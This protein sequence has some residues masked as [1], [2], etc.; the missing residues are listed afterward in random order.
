MPQPA[1]HVRPTRR[2]APTPEAAVPEA[3]V[4]VTALEGGVDDP[5]DPRF[6]A[7]LEAVR[8]VPAARGAT[9]SKGSL[10]QLRG[11]RRDDLFAVAEVAYAYLFGGHERVALVLFEGLAAVAP[12]EPY[13][14]LA[15]GLSHDFLGDLDAAVRAYDRAAKLDPEDPRPDINRAEIHLE[16]RELKAAH[17]LLARAA[18]KAQRDDVLTAKIQALDGQVRRLARRRG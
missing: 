15:C 18:G 8:V 2:R 4:V 12:D 17:S 7:E 9:P 10:E 3:Y 6:L 14:A 13:F 1:R 11:Y 5:L 16:R